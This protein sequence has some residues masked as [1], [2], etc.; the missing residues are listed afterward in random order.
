MSELRL[1]LVTQEWVVV[2]SERAKKPEDFR[3]RGENRK[4]S[5]ENSERVD[6]CPFC[7]GNESRTPSEIMRVNLDGGWKIRVAPNRYAALNLEGER[8]RTND[9]LKHYVTGVG[10]HEVIIESPKHNTSLAFMDK[11][12]VKEIIRV[13]RDRFTEAFNDRRIQHVIIFKNHGHASGTSITHPHSQ[14]IGTP[15]MPFQI[16]TRVDEYMR[17]YDNV[18]ECLMCAILK[19]EF[20]DGR[21]VI[22]DGRHFASFVPYAALSPF[23]MWI[24]PKRHVASFAGTTEEELDDLAQCLKQTLYKL[25]VGLDDPD[26]N[27]VIRSLS[28][29]RMRS[30]YLHWY[31]SIVPRVSQ[32]TGF[33]LGSGM[34][35]NLSIPEQ[36]ADFMRGVKAD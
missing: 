26:F 31:I 20:K 24:F 36:V 18:G 23:H 32:A 35:V 21:R 22:V 25:H 7:V 30:E 4:H 9:G 16:R 2:V 10:K 33:E 12:D 19:D 5:P 15:V 11:S 28:P 8:T 17:Y 6:S 3:Q 1:N 34:H 14:L 27:M 13:Y 29:F